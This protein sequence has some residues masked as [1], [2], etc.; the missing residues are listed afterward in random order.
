MRQ[1]PPAS[2]RCAPD[3]PQ[4]PHLFVQQ[5]IGHSAAWPW[6]TAVLCMPLHCSLRH[7]PHALA[8]PSRRC[9]C[10]R[11]TSPRPWGRALS[12][13]SGCSRGSREGGVGC[14]AH[15]PSQPANQ[16]TN[17]LHRL[18]HWCHGTPL[19]RL[20]W[21]RH[22]HTPLPCHPRMHRMHR[23]VHWCHGA[24]GLLMLAPLAARA[25][26]QQREQW[27]AAAR[28]VAAPQCLNPCHLEVPLM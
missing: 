27:V 4:L 5:A 9:A 6:C 22:T 26:P 14:A 18:V 8:L 12:G 24:P 25:L 2:S 19:S 7:I 20:Q 16:P 23:L 28:C 17:H 3:A 21:P 1:L 10:P 15:Q 11:A 13:T